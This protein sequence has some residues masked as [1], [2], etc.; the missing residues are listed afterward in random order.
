MEKEK[1]KALMEKYIS[2]RSTLEEEA[3]L[4]K[5]SHDENQYPSSWF[6]Y[7]KSIRK[8]PSPKLNDTIWKAI[9]KKEKRK[10]T[11]KIMIAGMSAAASIALLLVFNEPEPIS[12]STSLAEKKALLKEALSMFEDEESTSSKKTVLYEDEMIIIYTTPE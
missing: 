12:E 2:G 10:Y 1:I 9:Q 6:S 5:H 8:S 11:Y 7:L 3:L 4:I